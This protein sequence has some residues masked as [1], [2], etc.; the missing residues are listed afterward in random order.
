MSELNR[1]KDRERQR[2]LEVAEI[3]RAVEMCGRRLSIQEQEVAKAEDR[4]REIER[5]LHEQHREVEQQIQNADRCRDELLQ[6]QTRE[7]DAAIAEN[8][9]RREVHAAAQRAADAEAEVAARQDS[10][11]VCA[12]NL[13]DAANDVARQMTQRDA[14][15]RDAITAKE[16]EALRQADALGAGQAVDAHERNVMQLEQD[17]LDFVS[18]RRSVDDEEQPLL[19]QEVRLREQRDSL[20][21]KELKLRHDFHI[22]TGRAPRTTSPLSTKVG[23]SPLPATAKY[24]SSYSVR[25]YESAIA[26]RNI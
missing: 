13:R 7:Q 24:G 18:R 5:L 20:E 26:T 2:Q 22:F 14:D 6:L 11:R 1:A 21:T 19:E 3:Q 23:M 15:Q 17:N 9:A 8:E 12:A 25:R 16:R 10:E 4:L